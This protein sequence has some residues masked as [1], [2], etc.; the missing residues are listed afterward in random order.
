VFDDRDIAF[1]N[2]E[3]KFTFYEI[4]AGLSQ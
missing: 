4:I 1:M 3:Q 2:F